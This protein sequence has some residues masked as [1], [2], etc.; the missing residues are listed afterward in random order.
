LLIQR[1]GKPSTTS[2]TSSSTSLSSSSTS[3]TPSLSSLLTI[4]RKCDSP[5]SWYCSGQYPPAE[6]IQS[7]LKK[8]RDFK[9]LEDFNRGASTQGNKY[10]EEYM[11]NMEGK[12]KKIREEGRE[13]QEETGGETVM[14]KRIIA[15]KLRR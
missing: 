7:L 2:S 15:E 4:P 8:K 13:E 5:G 12:K 9:Q 10:Y 1:I 3:S 14:T 11:A 6:P